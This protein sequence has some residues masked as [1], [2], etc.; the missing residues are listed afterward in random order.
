MTYSNGTEIKVGD[1]IGFTLSANLIKVVNRIGFTL[2]ANLI[3]VVNRIGFALPD[4]LSGYMI[5][6]GFEDGAVKVWKSGGKSRIAIMPY[7][8]FMRAAI[9][10]LNS[11]EDFLQWTLEN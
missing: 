5:I 9:T 11:D 4:N 10:N 8:F 2:S 1:R 3:K 7:Q 6:N